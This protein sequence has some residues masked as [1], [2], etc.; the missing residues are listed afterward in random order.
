MFHQR[1]SSVEPP[2]ITPV[3]TAR[4]LRS[5]QAVAVDVRSEENYAVAHIPGAYSAPLAELPRELPRLPRDEFLIF[6][7][8]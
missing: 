3:D 1:P 7:C 4:L 5:G 6:Y 2:R 8:T